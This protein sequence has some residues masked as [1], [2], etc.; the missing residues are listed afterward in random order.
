MQLTQVPNLEWRLEGTNYAENTLFGSGFANG[1]VVGFAIDA[2]NNK[3]Y[4]S[5]NDTWAT[6]TG[7]PDSSGAGISFPFNAYR[8]TYGMVRHYAGSKATANYGQWEYFDGTTLTETADAKGYFRYT[9]PSGYLALNNDNLTET[10]SFQTAFSWTKNRDAT[11]PHMLFD[12]VRGR[13][14]YMSSDATTVET[15]DTNSLQ[16]FLK[17]GQLIGNADEM[18]TSMESFVS[19]DWFIETTG[20]GTA[21]TAGATD[22]TATLV[23]TTSGFS[24]STYTGTGSATTFGHGLGATPKLIIVKERTNDVGGWYVYH[25]SNTA[26]PET[27]YLLLDTSAATVD[28]ATVWN[29]T[30]PTS[31]VFSVGTH[32]D[33]NASGDTYVVYCWAEIEGFSAFGSY[34]G[35][36]LA[37]GPMIFTGMTPT[38]ILI[39]NTSRAGREWELY[40]NKRDPLNPNTESLYPDQTNAESTL[41]AIDFL[42]N[43][44]KMRST[45]TLQNQDGDTMIYVAFA[46]NPFGG[47]STTPATA[48]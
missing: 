23:D 6:A 33:V 25:A 35:N 12:R 42:S 48:V 19:W 13:Y 2:D 46:S 16:R 38:W 31:T 26:A 36:G 15:T 39:K 3:I 4:I 9:P 40:D 1:D 22:T 5:L 24:I 8:G 37:D 28:D 47:A 27:D 11:D 18:N 44:F 7:D 17:Q 21:N 20:S 45:D 14:D 30:A 10:D 43:G 34:T 32:D 29:D 41:G